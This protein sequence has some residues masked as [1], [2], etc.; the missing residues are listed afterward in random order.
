[1]N[2]LPVARLHQAVTQPERTTTNNN[3]NNTAGAGR[4]HHRKVNQ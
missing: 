2:Q 4:P 1:M 3:N